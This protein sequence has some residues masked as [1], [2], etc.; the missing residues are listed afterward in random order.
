MGTVSLVSAGPCADMPGRVRGPPFARAVHP[1]GVSAA[2][3]R[4][5]VGRGECPGEQARGNPV[6]KAG[7]QA[8]DRGLYTAELRALSLLFNLCC[9]AWLGSPLA[10]VSGY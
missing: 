6:D 10:G 9:P 5:R 3:L 2:R 1:R 8:G 4:F 7:R